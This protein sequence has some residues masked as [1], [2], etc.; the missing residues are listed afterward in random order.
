MFTPH[1]YHYFTT[2][3]SHTYLPRPLRLEF[4]FHVDLNFHHDH[5]RIFVMNSSMSESS[6]NET[7]R[8]SPSARPDQQKQGQDGSAS[9]F[10][11]LETNL[12][13]LRTLIICRICI[14]PL[15]EPYT[16]SCG[17]TFCY[18]CLRQWFD[19]DRAQKTCPDCRAK[20]VKQPAPAYLV[21]IIY[22]CF[23][24]L[25]KVNCLGPGHD[26]NLRHSCRA[27]TSR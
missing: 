20:V 11:S 3:Q 10:K 25:L 12:E 26:T 9:L 14:R 4:R 5:C 22:L 18:S 7:T 17:H 27:P 23:M 2:S 1:P 24:S 15:Y 13:D 8:K 6:K 16:I 21:S 19:R